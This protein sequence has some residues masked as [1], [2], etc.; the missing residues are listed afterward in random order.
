MIDSKYLFFFFFYSSLVNQ[1]WVK[2]GVA[3]NDEF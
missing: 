2:T 1:G 3:V